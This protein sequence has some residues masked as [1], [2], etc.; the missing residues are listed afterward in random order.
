MTRL[1]TIVVFAAGLWLA[2][3]S[4]GAVR[5]VRAGTPQT[6]DSIHLTL[7]EALGASS[8][9]DTVRAAPG[10]YVENV[11][12]GN[13]IVLEGAQAGMDACGRVDGVPDPAAESIIEPVSGI[14]IAL[15]SGSAGSIIDG[16]SF[17]GPQR[18]IQSA[19]GPIDDLVI[20]N[21]HFQGHDS[22]IF[23]NDSGIDITVHQNSLVGSTST[24]FHLD[25][26]NFDGLQVTDNCILDGQGTG[27]FVDGNHNVGV[28]ASRSPL[29]RGNLFE[30]NV[31]GANLGRFAFE[32]GTISGNTFRNNDFPGLQGGIQSSAITLNVFEGNGRGGLE[33]TGFG[34]GTDP[35]RGAQNN[36]VSCNEFSGNG[37]IN[38]GEGIFLSAG[39]FAG[40]ISTNLFYDNNIAGNEVGLSYG[41]TETIGAEGNWWGHSSGPF[42]LT[43]N[44]SGLGDDVE[45]DSVD[46]DPWRMEALPGCPI[47]S[48]GFESGGTGNW[49]V[50]Q[51]LVES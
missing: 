41:G 27:L 15:Q 3:P 34:G 8:D 7:Q 17:V 22:A 32:L 12:L 10:T 25:Q 31:T 18:G 45:G 49:S 4:F 40:T 1:T 38:A 50:T 39:Q 35:T 26:D 37:I 51:S 43:N 28:S 5:C 11:I 46:F 14:G 19:S 16:F 36:T 33:F 20:R 6:C 24:Q 2:V 47:F 30:G 29:I 42:N 48:D 23:L 13:Q 21:N 9:G 44:P